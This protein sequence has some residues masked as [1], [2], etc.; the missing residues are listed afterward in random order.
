[1][2]S[3]EHPTRLRPRSAGPFPVPVIPR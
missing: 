2:G 1:V 3:D